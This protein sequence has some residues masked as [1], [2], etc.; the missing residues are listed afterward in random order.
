MARYTTAYSSFISR[1][2]EVEILIR[3]AAEKEK[4]S[5]IDLR[6]EI[7][8][9]CRGAVVL[10]SSHLEAYIKE[11]GELALDSLHSRSIAR[12]DISSKFFYHISK[13]FFEEIQDISDPEKMADRMFSFIDA[14]LPYWSRTGAFPSQIPV[15]RFNK[16]FSNP[17]FSKICAYVG[18][19]GY[20]EYKRDLARTL[21]ASNQPLTNMVD[22][23][24]DMRNKIAHGDPTATK[25][26]A[27][28]KLMVKGVHDYAAATDS[29]FATW[30][31]EK[32]CAIR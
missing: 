19:F 8:A 25:P 11:L 26:P 2:D 20:A 23:L 13:S 21:G 32:F 1:L 14:D 12:T 10:L 5:P 22:Q 27:D 31:K 15:D 28:V 29:I 24:V 6:H 4:D 7:N 16:G 18:R 3:F 9:L 30:W 17:A